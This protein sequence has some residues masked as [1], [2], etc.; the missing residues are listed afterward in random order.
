MR[1]WADRLIGGDGPPPFSRRTLI[2]A[3]LS[4]ALGGVS[5][6][7]LMRVDAPERIRAP[8][9][10]LS[11][12]PVEPMDIG[13]SSLLVP[14][15]IDLRRLVAEV[16]AEVPREWGSLAERISLPDSG[17]AAAAI[18]LERSPFRGSM[19]GEIATL[20]ATVAYRVE[21]TYDLPILPDVNFSCG[22]DAD[23][24]PPRL[25]VA[26][27]APIGLTSDWRLR[28]STRAP[29]VAPA[30]DED[31]DRCRV[32]FMSVDV[33]DRV[34]RTATAFLDENRSVIDSIV[35]A[36]DVRSSFESWWD[37]LREPIALEEDVWLEIRPEAI[38]QGEVRGRGDVVEILAHLTAR[39]RIVLG[40]RPE[41]HEVTLPP[42]DRG[43]PAA[44]GLD[45][46]VEAVAE[47][48]ETSRLLN[49][50]LV[51]LEFQAGD[52]RLEILGL[53]LTGIGGGQVALE[54]SVQGAFDGRLYLVGTPRYDSETRYASVPD[55]A[56][57]V[58]TADLLVTGAS[59]V[60]DA[61]LERFLRERARWPIEGVVEWAGLQL[62]RGLNR[63]LVPGVRLEG[64]VH[65][66]RIVGLQALPRSLVVGAAAEAEARLIIDS[67]L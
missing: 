59:W 5:A 56:F 42:L 65:D 25:R 52:R 15:R 55:L 26:L 67:G 37:V 35:G 30:S 21:G 19:Q 27:R 43:A 49:E 32:T 4:L 10:D 3:L 23:E 33:T 51:G 28:T 29:S 31:R 6:W 20:A 58:S 12:R 24:A 66:V 38:R 2:V 34:V 14:I 45:V 53:Q 7:L 18:E 47:Y 11:T 22:T 8:R 61:G 54:V 48:G 36:A 63:T 64:T 50:R 57:S 62:D 9:P 44:G 46:L 13:P 60:V 41:T 16:E 39:P 40:P 17:R 1:E